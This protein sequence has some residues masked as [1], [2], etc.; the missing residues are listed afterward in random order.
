MQ[1]LKS[2]A[3][4]T[5]DSLVTSELHA[6]LL[7]RTAWALPSEQGSM[8]HPL[9][10]SPGT[11][12]TA[13]KRTSHYFSTSLASLRLS[14]WTDPPR[15]RNQGWQTICQKG[16]PL[17]LLQNPRS[18]WGKG[19]IELLRKLLRNFGIMFSRTIVKSH[20]VL[21]FYLIRKKNLNMLGTLGNIR[22]IN[23]NLTKHPGMNSFL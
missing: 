23:G 2:H 7:P 22:P 20:K 12:I 5:A 1:P 17:E 9:V 18:L 10:A 15:L 19:E 11:E 16:F 6:R 14:R 8:L 4:S 13:T 21:S 3:N